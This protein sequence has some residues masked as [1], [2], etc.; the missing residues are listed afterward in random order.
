MKSA[1]FAL[2]LSPLLTMPA[3]A[4]AL[5]VDDKPIVVAE[6]ADVRIGGVGVG[7]G[8]RRQH[9]LYMTRMAMVFTDAKEANHPLIFAND[10]F[11]SL[12]EYDREEV[13]GQRISLAVR[14]GDFD[15]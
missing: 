15:R 5:N 3:F 8:E 14:P 9:G 12:A 10:S 7:V 6:S 13:L 11:L 1:G 4:G 2:F